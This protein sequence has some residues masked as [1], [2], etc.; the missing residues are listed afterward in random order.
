MI[1]INWFTKLLMYVFPKMFFRWAA[2][3]QGVDAKKIDNAMEL[4]GNAKRIDIFPLPS[5]NGRGFVIILDKKFS[6]HFYQ[7]GD[8]FYYDGFEMGEY[9]KG[10]V[11]VFDSLYEKMNYHG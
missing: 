10:N 4:F 6:L 2:R 5:R 3:H 9:K 1:K 7:D 8:H 11:T